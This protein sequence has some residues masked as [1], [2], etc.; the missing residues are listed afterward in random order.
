MPVRPSEP[1]R[2]FRLRGG[3]ENRRAASRGLPGRGM[4]TFRSTARG[5]VQLH[6][7][8]KPSHPRTVV[9]ARVDRTVERPRAWRRPLRACWGERREPPG[10][11]PASGMNFASS[12]WTPIA[13]AAPGAPCSKF[14]AQNQFSVPKASAATKAPHPL[15]KLAAGRRRRPRLA[16]LSH[17]RC[18]RL[19]RGILRA[20]GLIWHQGARDKYCP[21]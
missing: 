10:G 21:E 18:L 4:Q 11:F 15:G 14:Q 6:W 13:A 2:V 12:G 16:P 3:P 7:S 1:D 17:L 19:R 8:R 20:A 9:P 5:Q